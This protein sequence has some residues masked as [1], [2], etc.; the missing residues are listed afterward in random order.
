MTGDWVHC[1]ECFAM[2]RAVQLGKGDNR[3]LVTELTTGTNQH[4][5]QHQHQPQHGWQATRRLDPF[6]LLGNLLP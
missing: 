2:R 6:S 5:H 4:Q 1:G 3:H